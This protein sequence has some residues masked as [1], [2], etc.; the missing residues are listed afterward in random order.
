MSLCI[1]VIIELWCEEDEN[2]Q[3]EAGI[4][5]LKKPWCKLYLKSSPFIICTFQR[6]DAI[7]P[8]HTSND[9]AADGD[10]LVTLGQ[11]APAAFRPR[12]RAVQSA[13]LNEQPL[14]DLGGLCAALET[15]AE[16]ELVS[17]KAIDD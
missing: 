3:T 16:A 9:L 11:I 6:F 8:S 12:G 10:D 15:E 5:T 7:D 13:A 17:G 4:G 2:E 1:E 14:D